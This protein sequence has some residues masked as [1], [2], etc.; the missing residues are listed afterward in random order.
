MGPSQSLWKIDDEISLQLRSDPRRF[1]DLKTD[2]HLTLLGAALSSSRNLTHSAATSLTAS[3]SSRFDG[4]TR[5]LVPAS[6]LEAATCQLTIV[7]RSF[8]SRRNRFRAEASSRLLR[9]LVMTQIHSP[10]Q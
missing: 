3:S 4:A 6:W 8:S 10:A 2:L 5:S 7:I 1:K 9:C